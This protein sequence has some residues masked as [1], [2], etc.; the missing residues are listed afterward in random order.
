MSRVHPAPE[1]A[2]QESEREGHTMVRATI[3]KEERK[4]TRP[5]Q[6]IR[7][8]MVPTQVVGAQ[9]VVDVGGE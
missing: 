8:R 9:P 7:E 2:G 5:P 6:M 1:E 3:S 4:E